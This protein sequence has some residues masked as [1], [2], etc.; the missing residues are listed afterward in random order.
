MITFLL[1]VV[2]VGVSMA[3][4]ARLV[5]P[6]VSEPVSLLLL[7][8]ALYG[9]S[10]V[11]RRRRAADPIQAATVVAAPRPRPASVHD[12]RYREASGAPATVCN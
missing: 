1:S 2:E 8:A 10:S 9:L 7:G 4:R 11:S 12:A 6:P 3:D 5:V